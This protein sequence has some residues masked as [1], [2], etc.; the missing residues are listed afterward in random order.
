MGIKDWSQGTCQAHGKRLYKT[1]KRAKAVIRRMPKAS[2]MREYRCQEHPGWWHIGHLPQATV[3]GL[4]T[5]REVYGG[6]AA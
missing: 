1:K 2:P 5:V 3:A 6:E 4:K